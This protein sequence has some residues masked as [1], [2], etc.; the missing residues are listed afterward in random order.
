MIG[1]FWRRITSILRRARFDR[2]LSE[3]IRL[4]RELREREERGA[5]A[6][7]EEA[8]YSSKRRFGNELQLREESREMWGWQWAEDFFQ[9][10]HYGLR[11]LRKN[12]G[13]T[14]IVVLTLGL[15]IG[16]TT[17]VFGVADAVLLKSLP[18]RQEKQL[19]MVWESQQSRGENH[20]VVS[21]ANF[22]YWQDHNTVFE[23]MAAFFDSSASV[24]GEGDPE[25][26]PIQAVSTN[27]FS[28]LGISP[29][30]GRDF[31]AGEGVAG[32]NHVA[33][34]SFGL[35]QRK[36]GGD[37]Q[38]VG[39]SIQLSGGK[40]LVVG[41][42][43]ASARLFVAKGSLTGAPPQMWVPI[44]WSDA[45]RVPRGRYMQAVAR[46]KNGVTLAEANGELNSLARDFTKQ[47][48]DFETGWDVH[49]VPVHEE[50]AGS[51]RKSLM[52]LLG[53][54]A[55][56]LL[57]A[58]ANV[59][60][61]V[62]SQAA[63]RE[64]ET[65]VRVALGAERGRIVRQK[66]TESL[67]LAVCGGGLG[68]L[69]ALWGSAALLALAPKNLLPSH[70]IPVDFRVFLFTAAVSLL[71]GI[72]L[73]VI[74]AYQAGRVSPTESL[75]E[76]G[77]SQ[78]A[79]RGKRLR[80]SFA[81]AEIA[82]SL[83]LLAG[84]GL[85]IRSFSRLMT[86]EPGFNPANLL[87]MRIS[88]PSARYPQT[89]QSIQFFQQLLERVR[90][91][92]GV[93]G[94]T[95]SNSFPL[96]GSTPGTDFDIIG[97]PVAPAGN[98][99]I[100]ELEM[101]D[102]TYFQTM[103]IPLLRGRTFSD[104]EEAVMSHVVII[105]DFI[106]RRYFPNEDPIGK[107]IVIDMKDT[108]V[109]SEIIGVVGDVRRSGLDTT[110]Q[111]MS[112]WPQA[113]LPFSAMMLG[114]RTEANPM[115]L[116]PTVTGIVH[117]MDPSLP[118]YDVETLEQWLGDSVA[119]QRFSTLLLGTFAGIAFL[120]AGVGVYGVVAYSVS[121][122]TR[123]FGVKMALGAETGDVAWI[124]LGH[125]LRIAALG[126]VFGLAGGLAVS[127][128]LRELLFHVSPYDPV[129]FA[130]VAAVFAGVTLLACWVPARRATKVDPMIALR[131]E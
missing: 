56:V 1:E 91:I 97:E 61:L 43:P 118:V 40:Y 14:A 2:E 11:V 37:G 10:I 92:P 77:R 5:G 63:A 85:L 90:A 16:A 17:A 98:R 33:I 72:V 114:I 13:F 66:L 88:L 89:S 127:Q 79:M 41:V 45:S 69:A 103:G 126:I 15:G 12:P 112:Y 59:A 120:L 74:P 130:I 116:A 23:Q 57:I 76:G 9:D 86:V 105:S 24:I 111:A 65:A 87:M 6:G 107:K 84:A 75:R 30:L 7:R 21:P 20:N 53:A 51:I 82:L 99:N 101:V 31:S 48:P 19:V 38:V 8:R 93:R 25:Q 100:T 128:F 121:Q 58:C 80:N 67:I 4:H 62:L 3:E 27:M 109:P 42:M 122:R 123:E 70:E 68:F 119:R 81:V 46:M 64:R 50:M 54:V 113:E 28:L 129:T 39:K 106:A 26:I 44:G 110:P 49:L 55:F 94:A 83:I 52:V 34:L 117:G 125:G 104:K 32:Q 29:V 47:Y 71:T 124:V 115:G 22:R 131:Y 36:F 60:N 18:Y 35:W 96:T 95:I 102:P 108:N 78:T 73:G